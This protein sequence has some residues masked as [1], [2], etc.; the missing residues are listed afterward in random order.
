MYEV[1]SLH[2][3]SGQCTPLHKTSQ[4][5]EVTPAATDN[6][7][8]LT[9]GSLPETGPTTLMMAFRGEINP[10]LKTQ[11]CRALAAVAQQT[12]HQSVD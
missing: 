2:W 1:R 4:L 5:L 8:L 12:E 10:I 9:A 7:E 3:R 11:N 6:E